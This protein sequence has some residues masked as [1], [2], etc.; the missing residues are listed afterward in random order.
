MGVEQ[1]IVEYVAFKSKGISPFRM[2]R[3]LLLLKWLLEERKVNMKLNFTF[4]TLPY[5]FYVKEIPE[6][7]ENDPCLDKE[8]VKLGE[9]KV[10]GVIRYVCKNPP[11]LDPAV[12]ELADTILSEISRL[13]DLELNRLVIRDVR[14]SKMLEKK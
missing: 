4:E 8:K 14:Y 2:S 10:T 6:I 11:K 3:I 5:G 1:D 12:R 9:G 13:N 7:I